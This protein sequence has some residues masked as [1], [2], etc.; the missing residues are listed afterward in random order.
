MTTTKYE[1]LQSLMKKY[2]EETLTFHQRVKA[3]GPKIVAAY[4]D[5]LGGP[6]F[7]ANSV[8]PD[9]QFEPS[10]M[11]RDAAYDS[12]GRGL[13][14]LDPIRMGICTIITNLSDDVSVSVR[15]VIE[16]QPSDAG[17][18]LVVGTRSKQIH[19]ESD[20]S[21]VMTGI[22]EAIFEDARE[23]FSL[24]LDQAQGRSRVGF[25]PKKE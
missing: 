2:G 4:D 17:L 15:T 1:E 8:P 25:N 14:Y 11:Y 20:L 13:L 7:S 23:A 24:A 3:I 16:F 12:F 10:E 21:L 6:K 22:C 19:L 5:Y 18:R 9:G